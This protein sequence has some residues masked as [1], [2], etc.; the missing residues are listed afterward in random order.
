MR[1]E[2]HS[3]HGHARGH[4]HGVIVGRKAA[5]YG[6]LSGFA[7]RWLYR[8]A[9]GRVIAALPA[10]ASLLD[11]GTGPG[12]LP[13]ELAR[14]RH[15]LRIV[16]ID[17]SPDMIR[18]ASD[19]ISAAGLSDRVQAREAGAEN[20][21]FEDGSFD[22]VISNGVSNLSPQKDKVFAEAARVLRPGGRLAIADIVTSTQLPEGVTCD[23]ALWAACIGGAMQREKY[24]AAIEAAGLK[25][26]R[27]KDNPEYRFIS[28]NAQ[29]ATRKF[30]VKSI[31]LLATKG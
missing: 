27:I 24:V 22:A 13:L 10:D 30:G 3:S 29:G 17:P 12:Q 4:A 28:D 15:D 19:R 1:H 9:A 11:V 23:A 21:P 8:R 7:L 2:G 26:A 5:R 31:S 16:G 18:Q 14:R 6:M 25:V 20:L